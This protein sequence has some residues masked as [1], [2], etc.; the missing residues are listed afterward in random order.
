MHIWL[1]YFYHQRQNCLFRTI[2]LSDIIRQLSL[3]W[4][5]PL[6][7][8]IVLNRNVSV[9]C[10]TSPNSCVIRLQKSA[11]NPF[12][13]TW[14]SIHLQFSWNI[15]VET[16]ALLLQ[17]IVCN[18]DD[19]KKVRE[20]FIKLYLWREIWYPYIREFN[21]TLTYARTLDSIPVFLNDQ[22]NIWGYL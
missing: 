13:I 7:L 6:C 2:T 1:H 15:S 20:I 17:K 18:S 4:S 10:L 22:A 5:L 14:S 11:S 19:R 3:T 16:A 12:K 21:H 9:C 8:S